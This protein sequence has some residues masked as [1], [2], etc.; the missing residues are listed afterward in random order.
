[1]TGPFLESWAVAEVIRSYWHAGRQAPLYYCRDKDQKEIDLLIFRD[2]TLYPVEIEKTT[3]PRRR[4]FAI[5][6]SSI[7]SSCRKVPGRLVLC[8]TQSPMPITDTVWALP[9]GQI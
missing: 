7:N 8:L 9:V 2:G 5:S 6:R 1:M 4:T 3:A